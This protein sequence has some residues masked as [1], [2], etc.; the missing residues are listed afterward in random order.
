MKLFSTIVAVLI[1]GSS[2]FTTTANAQLNPIATSNSEVRYQ[3]PP[4][5]NDATVIWEQ[6]VNGNSGIISNRF[7]AITN[8]PIALSVD[9][10]ILTERSEIQTVF[11]P[12]FINSQDFA[13]RGQGFELFIFAD[14]GD[15]PL[16]LPTNPSAIV[17]YKDFSLTTAGL[18]INDEGNVVEFTVDIETAG[19]EKLILEPGKYWIGGAA[20]ITSPDLD[21]GTRWNWYQGEPNGA[22]AHIY[23][24]ADF[25]SGC[26]TN[27]E[28]FGN[29][30]LTFT[31]LA[32]RIEGIVGVE[33]TVPG[34]FGL[35]TPADNAVV[36]LEADN[37][38]IINVSWEASENTT[39]YEFVAIEAGGDLDSDDALVLLSDF[40]GVASTLRLPNLAFYNAMIDR[41]HA[42]G[43]SV[44]MIWSVKAT[45]GNTSIFA[46]EVFNITFNMGQGTNIEGEDNPFEFRLAQNYPNPFNPTTN[47]SFSIPFAS[48]VTLEVFNMQ[49]QR[50]ATLV[51]GMTNAGAHTVPFNAE[52]LSSGIY[53]YRLTAG[54][55]SQTNKMMLVK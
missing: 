11:M 29:L 31:N 54:N 8:S 50:V 26:C 15:R 44:N 17:W 5:T 3:L 10:F 16:G 39:R 45:A 21:G 18:T 28:S 20:K 40:G 19:G 9:D 38:T 46:D 13:A 6:E 1:I 32:F 30:G 43:S 22:Q 49:G 34:P 53:M 24:P 7:T 33:E 14:N 55:F 36:T 25:F 23:A 27:W 12:G 42:E 4:A 35:L 52:S 48:D 2:F 37:S 41:G 47:I 51:N